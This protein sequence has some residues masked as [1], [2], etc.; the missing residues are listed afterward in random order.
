VFV[1]SDGDQ[2]FRVYLV[3]KKTSSRALNLHPVGSGMKR[4]RGADETTSPDGSKTASQGES[5]VGVK[6]SLFL[7]NRTK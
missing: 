3:L 1:G 7:E 2:S 4:E 5:A 6:K